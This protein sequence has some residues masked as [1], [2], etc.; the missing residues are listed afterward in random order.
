MDRIGHVNR[1]KDESVAQYMTNYQCE[2]EREHAE[3][4]VAAGNLWLRAV[5]RV[6]G[7]FANV[8]HL[9]ARPYAAQ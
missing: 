5:Q 1:R 8:I 7:L 6:R 9:A 3:Q 2:L 4:A